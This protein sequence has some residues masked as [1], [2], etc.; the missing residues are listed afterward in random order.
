MLN[1]LW[2]RALIVPTAICM[3]LSANMN[4]ENPFSTNGWA[5]VESAEGGFVA[6][7]PA[8]P[9]SR[10]QAE[11]HGNLS[12]QAHI[13][14]YESG[15]EGYGVSYRDFSSALDAAQVLQSVRDG[16]IGKGQKI[17]DTD[18]ASSGH[19]GKILIWSNSGK[20]WGSINYVVGSRLYQVI[21]TGTGV[22]AVAHGSAFLKAFQL[23]R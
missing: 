6:L 10:V 15:S 20:T 13:F 11:Q 21:Y 7:F 17:V 18:H 22:Q 1:T 2:M 3:L 23:T 9:Q 8:A 5:K 12:A 19:P 16:Q 4:A 14:S